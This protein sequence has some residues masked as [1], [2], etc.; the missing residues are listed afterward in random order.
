MRIRFLSRRLCDSSSAFTLGAWRAESLLLQPAISAAPLIGGL[1][2]QPELDMHY[3]SES[4]ERTE[5]ILKEKLFYPPFILTIYRNKRR[6]SPEKSKSKFGAKFFSMC[7]GFVLTESYGSL[8][9]GRN[10]QL[11]SS[12]HLPFKR[13]FQSSIFSF[14]SY[15]FSSIP[16]KHNQPAK[17]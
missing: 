8:F 12:V 17:P 10:L 14:L 6:N 7:V 13:C 9:F 15:Q 16:F 5:E 4:F 2:H 11:E 3:I 1:C